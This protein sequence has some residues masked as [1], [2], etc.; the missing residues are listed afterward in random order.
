MFIN[1]SLSPMR[2]VY[3]QSQ[4]LTL[5][6]YVTE[7]VLGALAQR[8][9]SSAAQAAYEMAQTESD[10]E[11][12]FHVKASGFDFVFLLRIYLF[13]LLCLLFFRVLLENYNR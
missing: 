13:L 6:E 11:K 8:V 4:I 7:G 3:V 9:A 2:F 10:G 5:V 1:V 12:I